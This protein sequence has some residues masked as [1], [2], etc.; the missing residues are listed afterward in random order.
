[1]QHLSSSCLAA[2]LA[3]ALGGTAVAAAGNGRREIQ[4]AIV[5]ATAATQVDTTAG[6]ALHLHHVINC[7]VGPH[8]KPYSAKAEALSE[9]PCH[10][11]GNGALADAGS[12][13]DVHSAL[14]RAL[15][16][17]QHGIRAGNLA[18]AHT[19]ARSALGALEAAQ[20]RN[21]H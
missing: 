3:V 7:L 4:V 21:H 17:A 11:L 8:G 10:T 19:D 12:N 14:A 5:H 6:V 20:R 16:D 1:M 2:V 13:R 15:A 18:A 9:N